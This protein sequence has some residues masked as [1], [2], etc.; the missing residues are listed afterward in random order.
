MTHEEML[1]LVKLQ[2]ETFHVFQIVQIVPNRPEGLI[3]VTLT[4]KAKRNYYESLNLNN[5]FNN[6]KFGATVK[7]LFSNK[8]K[9]AENKVLSENEKLIN[10]EEE[11]AN[12]FNDFFVNIVPNLCIRVKHDFLNTT[13]SSLD[14]IQSE[15]CKYENLLSNILIRKHMEETNSSFDFETVTKEKIEKLVTNLNCKKNFRSKD[16]PKKIV[17]D[18]SISFPNINRCKISKH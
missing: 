15:I 18:L 8:I 3:C 12:I 1:L 6:K 11:V 16:I 2:A 17:L 9:S 13:D 7:L 4:K 5:I 10:D 14:T